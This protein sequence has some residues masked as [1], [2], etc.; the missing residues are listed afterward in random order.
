VKPHVSLYLRVKLHVSLYLRVN[1]LAIPWSQSQT[2]YPLS[3]K[4]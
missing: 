3:V 4:T 1:L 2:T